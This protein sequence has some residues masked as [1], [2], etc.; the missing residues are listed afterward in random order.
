M[1]ITA[2]LVRY[3]PAAYG[4]A[5]VSAGRR[6]FFN[7]EELRSYVRNADSVFARDGA[8]HV[9]IDIDAG[10]V[11]QVSGYSRH[12]GAFVDVLPPEELAPYMK[13]GEN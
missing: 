4:P 9:C 5:Q 1:M 2:S 10:L 12:R 7:Q 13:G 6:T 8:G 11:F 3:V